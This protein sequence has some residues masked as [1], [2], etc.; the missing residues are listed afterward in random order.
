[1]PD[2]KLTDMQISLIEALFGDAQ[3]DFVEAKKIAGY[4]KSTKL[5]VIL[6]GGM[7]DVII[8]RARTELALHAP[9]AAMS[10]GKLLTGVSPPDAKLKL[11]A[12]VQVL[13][14]T[15]IVKTDI[16]QI[17]TKGGLFILPSKDELPVS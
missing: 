4:P 5:E 9:Q 2:I 6:G 14:R 16:I 10:L 17:D 3:G 1:M 8:E 7:K 11:A 13:D 15:N 12:I